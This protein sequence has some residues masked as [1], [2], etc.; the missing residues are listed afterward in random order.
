MP[1][2]SMNRW[3]AIA[4]FA[5]LAVILILEGAAISITL[6]DRDAIEARS[7]QPQPMMRFLFDRIASE[8][9]GNVAVLARP[10]PAR[11]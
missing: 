6:L 7:E 11:L 9:N 1:R 4:G 2:D 3:V 8:R 10:E 5:A